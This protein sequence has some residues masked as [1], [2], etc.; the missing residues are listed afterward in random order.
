MT[1]DQDAKQIVLRSTGEVDK[2]R[3]DNLQDSYLNLSLNN[4]TAEIPISATYTFCEVTSLSFE[5]NMIAETYVIG[6]GML[7]ISL[8]DL[9]Q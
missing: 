4:M 7:V 6:S 2:A 3:E 1:L 9:K 8:P 5:P